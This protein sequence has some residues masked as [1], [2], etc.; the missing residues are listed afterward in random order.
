M[1]FRVL[2]YFATI[3]RQGS[4]S[5]AADF[6]H[7]T[8][9]TLSRQI[10]ELEEELQTKLFIRGS[11]KIQLTE[12]GKQF[13]RRANEILYL[14]EQAKIEINKD[15]NAL[16]GD[17]YVGAAETGAMYY[18]GKAIQKVQSQYPQVH[19]H[20]YSGNSQEVMDQLDHDKLDFALFVEPV[21]L[22]KYDFIRLPTKDRWGVL[23][24]KDDEFAKKE[25]ITIHDLR[26]KPLIISD[27]DQFK[28]E[29]AGWI[30][31]NHRKLKIVATYNLL[32]NA[33]MLCKAKV[34]YILGLE[35]IVKDDEL[36]FRPL[37]PEI[38]VGHYFALKKYK[39][40]SR[41]A[42]YFYETLRKEIENE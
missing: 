20:I 19:F 9:P 30:G 29:L 31:G 39:I 42:E 34:G 35:N 1:E 27:Q 17:V 4:I 37:E 32:Y 14:V 8:Q 36:V 2:Y 12:D 16:N 25:K 7:I 3:V 21:N 38:T 6:L 22:Q 11:R 15:E 24:L 33:T 26:D 13:V 40:L 28:N 10:K 23:L 18:I 41:E 5:K